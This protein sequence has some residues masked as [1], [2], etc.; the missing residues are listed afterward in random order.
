M[1]SHQV[2]KMQAKVTPPMSYNL[3]WKTINT[4]QHTF[5]LLMYIILTHQSTLKEGS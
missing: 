4:E 3:A 1:S 5:N 2:Q